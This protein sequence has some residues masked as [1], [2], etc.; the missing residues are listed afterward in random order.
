MVAEDHDINRVLI[1]A[2]LKQLGSYPD[3]A[4]DG[5]EAIEK[6]EQAINDEDPYS[7]ILMDLQMPNVD[8]MGATRKLRRL[9][10]TNEALPIIAIT[11]HAYQE[12][13][14]A[15]HAAG[16]QEHLG[17]PII[18]DDLGRVLEKWMPVATEAEQVRV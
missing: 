3:I 4:E 18:K 17:K 10:V 11:A 12:D 15:C 7:I 9:G 5:A 1:T 16:M 13:I 6:I 8:G 2:L 14:K